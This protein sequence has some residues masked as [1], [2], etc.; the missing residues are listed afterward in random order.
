MSEVAAT[1]TTRQCVKVFVAT[2]LVAIALHL[3]QIAL[4]ARGND[5]MTALG[6]PLAFAS[7]GSFGPPRCCT[8]QLDPMALAADGLCWFGVAAIAALVACVRSKMFAR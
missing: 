8:Y 5:T 1:T 6:I 2:L 3:G 7:W 4:G